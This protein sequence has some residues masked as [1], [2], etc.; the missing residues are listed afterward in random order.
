MLSVK[1]T[2]KEELYRVFQVRRYVHSRSV[3]SMEGKARIPSSRQDSAKIRDL[4]QYVFT[5]QSFK[6]D[7]KLQVPAVTE[8]LYLHL[9]MGKTG[10]H[11]EG[12]KVGLIRWNYIWSDT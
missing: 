7:P 2:R 4:K 11:L 10:R 1:D 3:G 6:Q 12:I 5:W 9:F 8:F